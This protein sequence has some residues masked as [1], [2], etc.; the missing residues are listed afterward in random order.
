[1]EMPSNQEQFEA[2]ANSTTYDLAVKYIGPPPLSTGV[3]E[4]VFN[5]SKSEFT[6][7]L[8]TNYKLK[9]LPFV[10]LTPSNKDG[11]YIIREGGLFHK[12][13]IYYQEKPA[14]GTNAAI[15]IMIQIK[16]PIRNLLP[17]PINTPIPAPN[18]DRTE[19]S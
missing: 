16:T 18:P 4:Q 2:L 17:V 8:R 3:Y 1:M 6:E 11:Y 15:A 12:Y 14:Q 5:V 9:D 19:A 10:Y 7:W 13:R